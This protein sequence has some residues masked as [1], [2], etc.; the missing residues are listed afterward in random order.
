MQEL[1]K[2]KDEREREIYTK[3][4]MDGAKYGVSL[5]AWWKNGVQYVGCGILTLEQ[6]IEKLI[7]KTK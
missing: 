7:K 3:G 6:A 2:Y 1:F 5:Y 4:F